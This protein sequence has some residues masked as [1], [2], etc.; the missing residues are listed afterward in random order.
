MQSAALYVCGEVYY[1]PRTDEHLCCMHPW[2]M[3]LQERRLGYLSYTDTSTRPTA[4]TH[5]HAQ[6]RIAKTRKC[7]PNTAKARLFLSWTFNQPASNCPRLFLVPDKLLLDNQLARINDKLCP[8]P[9]SPWV[10]RTLFV[11][12]HPIWRC[13]CK[14]DH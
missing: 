10:T 14:A 1:S 9:S 4:C 6:L 8:P 11:D 3:M 13:F 7:S 12:F 5:R 2:E